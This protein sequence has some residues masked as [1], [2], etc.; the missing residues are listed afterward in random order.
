MFVEDA[1][2]QPNQGIEPHGMK[3]E[4]QKVHKGVD[5]LSDFTT[6]NRRMF[7]ISSLA[8]VVGMISAFVAVALL[9][10]IN[11]FTNLFFYGRLEFSLK[12]V[13]PA[14]NS[15]GI[16]VIVVPII[17]GLIVGVMARFGSERIRGHG[18]PEALESI[19]VTKSKMEPKIAVLKP[20]STAISIGSG[21]PFGAEGPIIMTGGA[22]G[23]VFSQFLQLT[24]MERKTLLVAGA[25]AGM[26]AVF[27]S[28]VAAVLLS[29]EL[30][31][32]EWKPRSL[33]P[34]GVACI[35]STILRWLIIGTGPLFP[36]PVTP[37]PTSA[38]PYIPVLLFAIV[39]GLCAGGL[40]TVL[41]YMVY[42]FEDTFRKFP[43]HWMWW[44]AIG[45]L[46]I[47]V[48]GFF[49]PHA[50]GVGYD[51]I[52]LLLG[53][54]NW[55][56]GVA[57]ISLT[58]IVILLIAKALMWSIALGSGTSGG[59]L[60]PLLIMGGSL[61]ALLSNIAPG[62]DSA[63][64]VLVSMGAVLGGTM[65]S[66]FTGVIFSVELTHDINAIF[67]LLIA[68]LFAEF[69]TVFTMKRS[70]L[71][72][73]VARRG[74]HV[75]REYSVDVLE[76]IPVRSVMHKEVYSVEADT[77]IERLVETVNT[78]NKSVAGYPIVD[79]IG[80]LQGFLS[81]SEI[82]EF[83]A[84]FPTGHSTKVRELLKGPSV[85]SF[86]DEPLR[87]AADRMAAANS[88][89]IPVVS[90]SDDQRV[91]GLVSRED[92]FHARVLWFAEEKERKSFLSIPRPSIGRL[93]L[94]RISRILPKRKNGKTND[95]SGS[96][97]NDLVNDEKNK[98]EK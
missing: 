45:A 77:P 38:I 17:G 88:D 90:I 79:A 94:C 52:G 66:P 9:E 55:I 16:L 14:E 85:V 73:K 21:G 35:T 44:P 43:V 10:L 20:V 56:V 95:S 70:I 61:G 54:P 28:P 3:K 96:G 78:S 5:E 19:L 65:R 67:P 93:T 87:V 46:A 49:A 53:S 32:F 27:N 91:I 15:L 81:R 69:V 75:A 84:K 31:L 47:G 39:V 8:V 4:S 64:W 6:V 51:T 26:A 18:I 41:T 71:T 82:L 25:A 57:Q 23:S 58:A 86:P 98:L 83:I 50:L 62:G 76:L 60:A 68:A 7:T 37:I 63:L 74:V 92:L 89:A 1:H 80:N 12:L 33:I 59:V 24:S 40:S 36:I 48:G 11:F 13:S 29:V 34:V 42:S 30:L 2:S 22:F 72:E 97:S